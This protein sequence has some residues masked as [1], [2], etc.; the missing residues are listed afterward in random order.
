MSRQDIEFKTSDNVI[1]RG[2]LYTPS[3]NQSLPGRLPCL[4]MSHA[5]AMLKE[6]GLDIFAEHFVS[7]LQMA[8]LVSTIVGSDLVT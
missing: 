6:M 4:V 7:Q 1:L 5:F 8:C 3:K 2:W